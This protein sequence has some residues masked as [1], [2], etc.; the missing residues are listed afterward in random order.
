MDIL[1]KAKR[2]QLDRVH[3]EQKVLKMI[4]QGRLVLL[5]GG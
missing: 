4:R 1:L 5:I 3:S 2:D